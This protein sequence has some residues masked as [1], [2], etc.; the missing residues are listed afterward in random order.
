[1]NYDTE[2]EIEGLVIS[3]S[4]MISYK[5]RQLSGNYFHE[6]SAVPLGDNYLN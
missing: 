6:L 3:V 2:L 1:M 5:L 4:Y